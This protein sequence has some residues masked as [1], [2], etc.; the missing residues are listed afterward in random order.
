M[1]NP[2]CIMP[3]CNKPIPN[4]RIKK[5]LKRKM[6]CCCK[7]CSNAWIWV[8]QQKRKELREEFEKKYG[9]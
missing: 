1:N 4:Y 7:Q 6:K 9:Y 3:D 8:S 5:K 2:I